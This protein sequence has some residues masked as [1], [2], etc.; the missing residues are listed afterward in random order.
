MI[1]GIGTDLVEI[2]RLERAMHRW[3][4]RLARRV[5]TAEEWD[6]CSRKARPGE[7][8]A[9]RFAAKEAFLKALGTGLARGIRWTD[10]EV[11]GGRGAPLLR[12]RGRA[13]EIFEEK[14]M[15]RIWVSLTHE[16]AYS[17]AVVV[18]EG[19]GEGK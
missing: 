8:L 5:F 10:V 17:G 3:G 16:G 15:S 1:L 12:I 13:R 7:C 2:Q 6:V 4:E 14:G 11:P 9:A 18:V 19:E